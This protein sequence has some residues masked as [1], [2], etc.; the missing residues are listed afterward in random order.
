MFLWLHHNFKGLSCLSP[1]MWIQMTRG[2]AAKWLKCAQGEWS[3]EWMGLRQADL[4]PT[5]QARLNIFRLLCEPNKMSWTSMAPVRACVL[6]KSLQA[7]P[8][9]CDLLDCPCQAPWT[10]RTPR[11]EHRS[12]LPCLP[13]GDLS[14]S[15]IKPLSP[16]APALQMTSLPLS[17]AGSPDM[18]HGLPVF[19]LCFWN[20][21]WG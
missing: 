14:D 20:K 3:W 5:I 15:G 21:L 17:H 18:A 12:G 11:R 8:T 19:H 7:C 16:V 2:Q 13:P 1:G 9:L 6:A 10:H 4:T